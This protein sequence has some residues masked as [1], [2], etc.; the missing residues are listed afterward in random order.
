MLQL[1][2]HQ[3]YPQTFKFSCV[4]SANRR[5]PFTSTTITWNF[6]WLTISRFWISRAHFFITS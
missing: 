1:P 3:N 4:R 5:T 6:G 2:K